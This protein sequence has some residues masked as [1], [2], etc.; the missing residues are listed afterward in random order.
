MKLRFPPMFARA[1]LA[2][3]TAYCAVFFLVVTT[4]PEAAQSRFD[5]L[6][7]GG[8]PGAALGHGERVLK[9]RAKA[10]DSDEQLA[11]FK[12]KVAQTAVDS[13]H[14]VRGAALYEEALNSNWARDMSAVERAI[15]EDRLA[16]AKIIERDLTRPV[17]IYSE[18]LS[19]AGDEASRGA[20]QGDLSVET[21]YA[22]LVGSAETLFTEAMKPAGNPD[23]F[24]GSR[25]TRLHAANNLAQ[26]G[27]FYSM[28][29]NGRY[30]AAG[31]LASALAIRSDILGPDH[32]DTVQIAL[33][34]GPVYQKLGR[35]EDAEKLYLDAFHAQEKVKGSNSPELSLYIK[36]LADVYQA[37]GRATEAQALNDHMRG[38]FR[39]AFGSQ[40]Y[41]ANRERDRKL[42]IDRP[43]SQQFV[44]RADYAP[45]DLVGAALY[46]V[47]L[48]KNAGL[49]EMKV[50]LAADVDQ[51]PREANLPVR[52]AQLMSL[53]RA[54][55]GER[56]SLRS[57]YRA[58]KTQKDLFERIGYKGTVTPPGMSEHQLGLAADID[59][60]GRLMRQS[61]KT[62]QCFEENAFR[63]GFILSYPPDNDYLPGEDSYE[64]WHWRYV[65]IRTAQLYREAGPMNK[66]QE[67][68][69]AL[70]CYQELAVSGGF[71]VAGEKD[72]C[73]EPP[74]VVAASA[75]RETDD[76]ITRHEAEATARK[77]NNLGQGGQ[78]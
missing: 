8:Y 52:L 29:E 78:R 54:D 35:L 57:G 21:F 75:E 5:A 26:L 11:P 67:F 33:I 42:D 60:N 48:S 62:Y 65:G 4:N 46:S 73:L 3:A 40:R 55:S 59:V 36:L 38:L 37:Q 49:D 9:L 58:Y 17:D 77:L 56:I 7:K 12:A 44:L 25:D 34:L 16:R 2:L 23:Y 10:G 1:F 63:Y 74:S 19:L 47:P 6:R 41:A 50:R 70:P 31:L 61:D 69:A 43:V 53:C 24:A 18:F 39:D 28:R 22:R 32:P 20:P 72:R 51:D 66:P 14:Y 45:D 30:A 64:P 15:I 76:K 27:A 71:N 68:L 13:R